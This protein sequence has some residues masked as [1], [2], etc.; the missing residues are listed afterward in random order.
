MNTIDY[1]LLA[2]L[3]AGTLYTSYRLFLGYILSRSGE[4]L[5]EDDTNYRDLSRAEKTAADFKH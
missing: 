2:A 3:A 4:V 5:A 1:P